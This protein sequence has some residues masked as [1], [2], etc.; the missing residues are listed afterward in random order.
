LIPISRSQRLCNIEQAKKKSAE[1]VPVFVLYR[2][3]THWVCA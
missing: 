3:G 1:K 2:L